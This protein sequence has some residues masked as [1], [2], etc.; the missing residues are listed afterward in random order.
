MALN[1]HLTFLTQNLFVEVERTKTTQKNFPLG[2]K[3]KFI[4]PFAKVQVKR[5]C[6]FPPHE[7]VSHALEIFWG[8][9][10]PNSEL[11]R[12]IF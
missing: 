3:L 9:S 10:I 7:Q 2:L 5:V 12:K 6:S 1:I 11:K 8:N 4:T